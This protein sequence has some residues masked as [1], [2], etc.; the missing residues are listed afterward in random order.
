MKKTTI[1]FRVTTDFKDAIKQVAQNN[2]GYTVT[3]ILEEG[4]QYMIDKLSKAQCEC[5]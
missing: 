5:E 3:K 4:G 2:P 1:N